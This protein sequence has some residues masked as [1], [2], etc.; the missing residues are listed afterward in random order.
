MIQNIF[1]QDMTR[2][3]KEGEWLVIIWRDRIQVCFRSFNYPYVGPEALGGPEKI[4]YMPFAYTY[5][6]TIMGPG[7]IAWHQS[8]ETALQ[9]QLFGGGQVGKEMLEMWQMQKMLDFQLHSTNVLFYFKTSSEIVKVQDCFFHSV[10]SNF[11]FKWCGDSLVMTGKH[12]CW[13]L[14]QCLQSTFEKRI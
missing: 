5:I 1:R 14:P 10:L 13:S 11:L 6:K 4:W 9:K 7:E 2:F 12:R 8:A 3:E